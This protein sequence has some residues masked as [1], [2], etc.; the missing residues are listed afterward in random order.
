M[1][2]HDRII[3]KNEVNRMILLGTEQSCYH[4]N[5]ENARLDILKS[6]ETHIGSSRNLI[7]S[8]SVTC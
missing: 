2:E 8:L 4:K 3:T 5:T 6:V 7:M 1:D